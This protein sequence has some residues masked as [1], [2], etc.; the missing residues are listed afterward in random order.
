VEDERDQL[1]TELLL[2][3]SKL[4]GEL[5]AESRRLQRDMANLRTETDQA[6]AATFEEIKRRQ[7]AELARNAMVTLLTNELQRQREFT[8]NME[9][10]FL[11]RTSPPEQRRHS[12]IVGGGTNEAIGCTYDKVGVLEEEPEAWFI[13][14]PS[15][16]CPMSNHEDGGAESDSDDGLL[17]LLRWLGREF[18]VQVFQSWNGARR[19]MIQRAAI[20]TYLQRYD[21][22]ERLKKLD[23]ME[24]IG[25]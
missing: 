23:L 7:T 14:L 13:D 3:L 22:A 12:V 1:R 11:A 24:A 6:K 2:S 8:D 18:P 4:N 9:K 5:T 21:G 10:R 17:T 25:A 19:A 16:Q 15:A 20:S